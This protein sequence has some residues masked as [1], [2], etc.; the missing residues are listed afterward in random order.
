MAYRSEGNWCMDTR[1][2]NNNT[3]TEEQRDIFYCSI[4]DSKCYTR[5]RQNDW[6][7]SFRKK[8]AGD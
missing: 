4:I 2:I 3:S 1:F 7:V 6:T 8:Q 5:L